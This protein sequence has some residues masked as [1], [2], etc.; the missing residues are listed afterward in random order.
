MRQSVIRNK[1]YQNIADALSDIVG[2][3]AGIDA[4]MI[5]RIANQRR[6]ELEI[7]KDRAGKIYACFFDW[8]IRVKSQEEQKDLLFRVM[9]RILEEQRLVFRGAE[10]EENYGTCEKYIRQMLKCALLNWN[11]CRSPEHRIRHPRSKNLHRPRENH[12]RPEIYSQR[13]TCRSPQRHG[14]NREKRNHSPVCSQEQ[15]ELFTHSGNNQRYNG[16]YTAIKAAIFSA[17]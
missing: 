8:H 14:Q 1:T 4:P 5:N 7:L 11:D 12:E 3:M 9:K 17:I 2:N 16:L 13:K 10:D 15:A 6:K